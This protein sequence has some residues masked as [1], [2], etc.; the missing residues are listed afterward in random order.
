VK[1]VNA[2]NTTVAAWTIHEKVDFKPLGSNV[3]LIV[4]DTER[5]TPQGLF[6]PSRD[7]EA[8][9]IAHVV[10][11][12]EGVK[13]GVKAGDRVLFEKYGGTP[14][15]STDKPAV[16]ILDAAD[17]MAVIEPAAHAAPTAPG[18]FERNLK[19]LREIKAIQVGD[20]NWNY[21]EYMMGLANGLIMAVHVMEG[22]VGAP[23]FKIR[24][25]KWAKKRKLKTAVATQGVK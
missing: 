15:R 1:P 8:A 12:G 25:K 11:V 20:G 19:A 9:L 5:K 21:D 17:I 2:N 18:D 6:L 16:L 3:V 7:R 24:P 23:E 4:E 22:A 10:A 13:T 14:I